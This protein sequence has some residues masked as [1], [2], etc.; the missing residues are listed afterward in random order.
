MK[1]IKFKIMIQIHDFLQFITK[2][3]VFRFII[4]SNVLN[5]HI[6]SLSFFEIASEVCEKIKNNSNWV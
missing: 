6:N 2:V 4:K 3:I 5:Y 1:F